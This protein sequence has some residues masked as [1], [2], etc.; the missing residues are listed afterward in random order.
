[1]LAPWI[2]HI[3]L[4]DAVLTKK[5]GTWGTEVPWGDGE[6]DAPRFLAELQA[7]GY[8]GNFAIEREGG[9]DRAGDIALAARRLLG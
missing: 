5:P 7:A 8:A 2:R 4:K 3:H 9:N 1:M 6:V